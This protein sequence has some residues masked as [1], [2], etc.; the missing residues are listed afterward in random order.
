MEI[1]TKNSWNHTARLTDINTVGQL[2]E[3]LKNVPSDTKIIN[4]GAIQY[5]ITEKTMRMFSEKVKK[6]NA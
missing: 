6:T 1:T 4:F 5:N 3:S 2:I